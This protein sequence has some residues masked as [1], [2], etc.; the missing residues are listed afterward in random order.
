MRSSLR[1][2]II[3]FLVFGEVMISSF[4]A[5]KKSFNKGVLTGMSSTDTR[6]AFDI[7]DH[8]KLS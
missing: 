2:E 1:T 4:N 5:L 7:I 6:N 3:S 8:F